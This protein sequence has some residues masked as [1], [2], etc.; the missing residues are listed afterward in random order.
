L[1]RGPLGHRLMAIGGVLFV[2]ATMVGAVDHFVLPGSGLVY[3]EFFIWIAGLSAIV[4]GGALRAKE[5]RRVHQGSLFQIIAMMPNT[6][7]YLIGIATLVLISLPISILSVLSPI[8]SKPAWFDVGNMILWAFVFVIMAIAERR[9]H[10]ATQPSARALTGVEKEE[11]MLLREDILALR[12]YSDLTSRLAA[13]AIPIIGIETLRNVLS[14][15]ADEHDIL[16]GCEMA[17]DGALMVEGSVEGLTNISEQEGTPKVLDGFSGLISRFIEL[18]SAVASPSLAQE[19]MAKNYQATRERYGG[20][21][22]LLRILETMPKGFLEEE[23]LALLSK[24]ELEARVQQRTKELEEAL[25]KAREATEALRASR[26]SFHNIVERSTDGI[27]VIDRKGVAR[28]V[29]PAAGSL[30]GCKAGDHVGELFGFPVVADGVTELDI[31]YRGGEKGVGEL[32]VVKTE[33]EGEAADLALLRD[34]TERK[35]AQEMLRESEEDLRAIF[36][37]VGDG[38]AI[39]DTTGKVVKINQR[40]VEVGGYEEDEIVGK[41]MAL[42]KMFPPQSLAKMLSNFIRLISSQY[43]PPF[44]VEAYTKAG[45]KRDAELRG[46]LL[47]KRGRVV[48]VVGVMRD[49]TERKRAEEQIKASLREKEVLLKEIHH[50]VKNNLQVISSL[51]YL[52][53][54]NIEDREILEM[55]Q[56]SQSRVRSMSLVHERLYQSQDL[57]RIDFG[58]YIRNLANYLLGSY[59]AD[60][61]VIQLKIHV[62]DVFLGVDTAITCGL[63]INELV[64]NCLKYAFPDGQAGEICIELRSDDESQ[65]TLIVSD[66]GGGLPESLDFRDTRSLGL[67]LVNTLVDQLGGAI[68]LDRSGGTAFKITFA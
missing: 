61:N 44:D 45:E 54:K 28:F 12:A 18:Y 14:R 9:F 35:R 50:R 15:H 1:M 23:K 57:A 53:S 33:W 40:I 3:V 38:I 21:P 29:N 64:S 65:F 66:N 68:E 5:I 31:I 8:R 46:S 62:D 16:K 49:I 60:A 30:L 2:A 25:I 22:V 43:C 26:A 7:V 24:E 67:Q 27:I 59:G 58:E 52:Q 6:K 36:D 4:S 39:I 20:T 37:G 32:R 13:T 10:L 51:L 63:I 11:E 47:R 42:L 48:G 56:D 19:L 34:I 55:F 41:R 17:D